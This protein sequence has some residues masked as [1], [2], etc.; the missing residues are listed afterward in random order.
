MSKEVTLRNGSKKIIK[1]V[2]Y[3]V[4]VVVKNN[5]STKAHVRQGFDFPKH[6]QILKP[7]LIS[8]YNE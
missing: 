7:E 3:L 6:G 4:Q 8:K 5:M 1:V 2:I